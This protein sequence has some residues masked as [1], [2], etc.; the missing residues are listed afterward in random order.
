M[1]RVKELTVKTVDGCNHRYI[2]ATITEWDDYLEIFEFG[3]GSKDFR[4]CFPW[5]NIINFSFLVDD[6]PNCYDG[7]VELTDSEVKE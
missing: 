4:V 7:I 5:R 1:R 3:S 2:N 6:E